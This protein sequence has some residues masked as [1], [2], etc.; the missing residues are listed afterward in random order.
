MIANNIISKHIMPQV[1][2]DDTMAFYQMHHI[3][4]VY[5]LWQFYV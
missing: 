3:T 2:I 1:K 5:N 4:I